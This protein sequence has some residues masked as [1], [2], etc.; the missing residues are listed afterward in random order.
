MRKEME[1]NDIRNTLDNF[2]YGKYIKRGEND[3]WL[4]CAGKTHD[5][6][7]RFNYR[8]KNNKSKHIMAH[9]FMWELINGAIPEGLLVL[10]SCDNPSCVNPKHLFLGTHVD[11]MQDMVSK[12]RA[13]SQKV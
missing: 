1:I 3:C 11:N 5:G 12:G 9:R 6:Y 7:G 8:N 2:H 10:H 13:Y 4:W